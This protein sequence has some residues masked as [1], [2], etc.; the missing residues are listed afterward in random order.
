M[1]PADLI[2]VGAGPAGA[3]AALAASE[4]GLQVVLLDEAFAPGGQVYRA[5]P[6]PLSVA[7]AA[8]G[9]DDVAGDGLRA[10]VAAS[11]VVWKG[12]ARVWS[13]SGAFRVDAVTAAGSESFTAPRLVAATGAHERLV[14]FPGWTTPGVIGLAAATIL[15]KSQGMVPGRRTVVAGCGPLLA[16]VAAKIVA[17]GG[18][19]AA[20]VD[21]A[22]PGDWLKALPAMAS[23]P[24]LLRQGLGWALKLG[25]A[26]VPVLFR[27][28][29]TGVS[30]G[31]TCETVTVAPVDAEGRLTGGRSRVFD[32]DALAIGHGLVPGCEIPKL[33]RAAHRFAPDA[34]GWTP[35]RDVFGRCSVA[36]LYA[37]G[38]G[39]A[40]AGAEP[41]RLSGRLAGLA[42]AQD[43]GRLPDDVFAREAGEARAALDKAL[44][45]AGAI[46]R[47]MRARPAMVEA[48]APET[49]IC[50]CEDVRRGEIEAA[51]AAGAR[52]INQLKH[53][54]RCG[55]GPCQGRMCGETAA[56]LLAR[57]VGS[58]EA[59]GYWTGRPPLRP[60]PLADLLGQFDYAD[61]PVP[62][63]A[64]L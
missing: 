5:P 45:F 46:N 19:V 59:A 3:A 23:R 64:P 54:T 29:V 48:I 17:G 32:V 6:P 7:A 9:A 44:V 2:V 39:A 21:L 34:G 62:T 61:I 16:A 8:R 18:A 51:I 63:P 4:A 43:A 26:R 56:T 53:F 38:D 50:R 11:A 42:V 15:L 55:M 57:H 58:R 24:D 28:M 60:V 35:E 12:G 37:V 47:L 22:G 41:A 36:G 14:P 40:V 31:E 10:A 52:E 20:V 30:G 27:H 25:A 33:L 1:T 13:I 49:V